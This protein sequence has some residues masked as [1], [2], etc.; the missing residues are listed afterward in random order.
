MFLARTLYLS[1][2]LSNYISKY[3]STFLSMHKSYQRA[4]STISKIG[5]ISKF[6][7]ILVFLAGTEIIENYIKQGQQLSIRT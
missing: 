4:E 6:S 3:L 1:I 5:S 2:Y 7:E